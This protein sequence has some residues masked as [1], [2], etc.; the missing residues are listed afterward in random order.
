MNKIFRRYFEEKKP[1][2]K[3]T[4]CSNHSLLALVY[5]SLDNLQIK[6]HTTKSKNKN[7]RLTSR[8]KNQ[9]FIQLLNHIK[10]IKKKRKKE[11]KERKKY[12]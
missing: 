1:T 7:N 8:D 6:M 11:K 12:M 2:Q 5:L 10:L 3:E 9:Y 4:N